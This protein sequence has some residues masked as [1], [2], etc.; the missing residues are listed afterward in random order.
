MKATKV[1]NL[2]KDVKKGMAKYSPEILTGVGVAGMITTTFLAVKATP[3]AIRLIENAEMDKQDKLTVP[4]KIKYSWKPYLPAAITGV[5]SITCLIGASSVNAKRNAAL[6]TAYELTKTTLTEYREK[7]KEEIGEKKEKTIREKVA[8]DRVTKNPIDNNTVIITNDGEQL[9]LD[10]A[11]G[12]L[13]KSDI[14]KI[15]A[16]INEVNRRMIYSN[17]VSLSEFYDEL[18]LEHTNTSDY[19]GWNLDSGLI[20]VEYDTKIT[21][22]GRSCI[23]LDYLVEPRYDYSKLM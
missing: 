14:E 19:L 5:A 18:G 22:D 15:K 21:T 6:A 4:E 20:E 13:F 7:V 1:T 3:K 16:A 2:L 23:T 11:S 9:F 10:G 12:R 8:K 17:Y